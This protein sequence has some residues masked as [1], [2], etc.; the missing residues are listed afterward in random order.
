M[1]IKYQFATETVEIEVADDWGSL[2]ID[3]DREDYN[4]DHAETRRHVSY[5]ALDFDGDALAVEDPTLTA[6]TEQ[7][8]LREAIKQLTPNQQYIIR[9]YY[10]EGRTFTEIAQTLGV[11]V[12]SVTRAADRAKKTLKKFL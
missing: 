7:D 3:L 12:S 9:A 1:K 10:F 4:N 5:D 6:Y 8:A 2:V 11:G